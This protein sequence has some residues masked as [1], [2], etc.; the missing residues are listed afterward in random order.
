MKIRWSLSHRSCHRVLIPL[1]QTTSSLEKPSLMYSAIRLLSRKNLNKHGAASNLEGKKIAC[2]FQGHQEISR[3]ESCFCLKFKYHS[4]T[5]W[6]IMFAPFMKHIKPFATCEDNLRKL[7]FQK[8]RFTRSG[9]SREPGASWAST[10]P[11]SSACHKHH[12]VRRACSRPGRDGTWGYDEDMMRIWWGY[13]EDWKE[14]S[15][16]EFT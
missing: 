4:R 12:S 8:W 1:H 7:P 5:S 13:D 11:A 9:A 14:E 15:Q 3:K 10:F 16:A 6:N 2:K